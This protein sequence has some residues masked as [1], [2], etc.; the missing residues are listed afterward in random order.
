MS[1]WISPAAQ[2]RATKLCAVLGI[3]LAIVGVSAW[4][5]AVAPDGDDAVEM[6]VVEDRMYRA[7]VQAGMVSENPEK[8]S[9][10]DWA[11]PDAS[12]SP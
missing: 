4:W 1:L 2:A 5:A 9:H 3:G 6:Q 8:R 7:A 11:N 10:P 12:F